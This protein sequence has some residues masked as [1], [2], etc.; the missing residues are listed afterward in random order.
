M[1]YQIRLRAWVLAMTVLGASGVVGASPVAPTSRLL[2]SGGASM[3]AVSVGGAPTAG[4]PDDDAGTETRIPIPSA[5][6]SPGAYSNTMSVSL[7]DDDPLAEIHYTLDGSPPTAR[8]PVFQPGALIT[9]TGIYD[10]DKGIE[11]GYTLRAVAIRAGRKDSETALFQ[12]VIARRDRTTYVSEIVSPGVRMIR[13]S[14]N[15]KMYLVEGSK[16]FALIDS[17]MGR[18]NLRAYV[19]QFTHGLPVVAIWTHSHGD[20]IGQSD[21][22][23]DS[24]FEYAGSA[25]RPAIAQFLARRGIPDSVIDRH[26]VALNDGDSVDLGD[27][28]LSIYSVP[29]HT[30]GSIIILDAR[31]GNLFTGDTFG[32]NS[33]LPPD[34]MWMQ[35]AQRS[36]DA[37]YANVID[38]RRWINGRAKRVFTGHNDKALIGDRYLDNLEVALQRAMDEG[39][40]A[41]IP[42]Y[43]P[44][45]LF[46]I[47]VGDRRSDPNWFG[48]NVNRS[49][50]LPA[51]PMKIA[52]LVSLDID[53]ATLLERFDPANHVY[54]AILTGRKADVV[55]HARPLTSHP[56][57][58]TICGASVVRRSPFHIRVRGLKRI[59][60]KIWS[61]DGSSAAEY[62]ILLSRS[63]RIH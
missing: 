43:R 55:V 31:E 40:G 58:M 4:S 49:T 10:G 34:V 56:E 26:L 46:Q 11:A 17:G 14:D 15:D 25:D 45:G 27:R 60:I 52:A 19:E 30:P 18:G 59:P 47:V 16:K 29:G 21:Q 37:Y 57:R 61:P 24:S 38:A 62:T 12:Y 63:R 35:S 22:F 32:N 20:H 7:A 23:I 9:L 5:F 13:D 41:L 3:A 1:A 36:L 53:G 8:S 50:F 2:Q 51:P 42:S 28:K 6:P 48:I 39:E 33:A 54:H 44:Q